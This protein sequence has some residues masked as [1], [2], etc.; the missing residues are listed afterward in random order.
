MAQRPSNGVKTALLFALLAGIAFAAAIYDRAPNLAHVKAAFLSG[1]ER[2]NYY[3]LVSRIAA[4]VARQRGRLDNR[5]SAGSVE[6][7]Q[8]LAAGKAAC[9]VQFALVQDGL[10]WP[11]GQQLE[12]VGRLSKPESFVIL[13]RAAD[14]IKT[15]ADLRGLRVGIG[16]VGSGTERVARQLLEPLRELDLQLSTMPIDVQ[17]DKLQSGELDLGAMVIDADAQQLTEAVRARNLQIVD[18]A[19]AEVIARKLPFARAGRIRAGQ[20]DP[21]RMLPAE[22]KRV[23]EIDTLVVGN[24]CAHGSVTQGLITAISRVVPDFVRNNH[25]RPNLTGLPLA[26]AAR[27]YFDNDGPDVVGV[28][29]PWFIDIMPTASWLQLIFGFSLLFNAMAFWHRYRLWRID[30]DRVRVESDIPHLFGPGITV[31]EI[32]AMAP[33]DRQLAPEA[34]A[35]LDAIID[36]LARIAERCRKQSLSVLVPMGQEMS[37]RYQE[38]LIAELLHALRGF[39]ERLRGPGG[40]GPENS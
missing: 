11:P 23:I 5:P 1:G 21:V 26:S 6:N 31:G 3:A 27:S 32:G 29:V 8:L 22:D 14:R 30:A 18:I 38:A 9:T 40:K 25:D 33:Q 12:L 34:R 24:G 19:S 7:I 10:E 36:E 28:H 20:Y 35:K 2:G 4:E 39:R 37:Y 16:P 13:G 15:T 17:L